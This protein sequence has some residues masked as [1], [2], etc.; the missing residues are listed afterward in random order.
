MPTFQI[1]VT[2]QMRG[3]YHI[4]APTLKEAKD[5]VEGASGEASGLPQNAHLIDDTMEVDCEQMQ[6][7]NEVETVRYVTAKVTVWHKPD[8]SPDSAVASAEFYL[9]AKALNPSKFQTQVVSISN[10]PA[11]HRESPAV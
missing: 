10:Q 5:M 2:Y 11:Q 9:D 4:D 3:V 6:Y 7:L 1:P 8:Q